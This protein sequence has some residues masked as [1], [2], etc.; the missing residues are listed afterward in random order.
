MAFGSSSSLS[1]GITLS[2]PNDEQA[3]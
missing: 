2:A 3:M 1:V